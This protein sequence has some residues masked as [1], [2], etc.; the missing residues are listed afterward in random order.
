M[1][2]AIMNW[3]KPNLRLRVA[4][5][6]EV[7]NSRRHGV[8][9]LVLDG[10]VRRTTLCNRTVLRDEGDR[11]P[12]RVVGVSAMSYVIELP[13]S[14]GHHQWKVPQTQL[15]ADTRPCDYSTIATKALE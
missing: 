9:S 7:A 1:L 8:V 15:D 14:D 2:G 13:S 4:L 12:R 10:R 11:I 3:L 6:I 5:S